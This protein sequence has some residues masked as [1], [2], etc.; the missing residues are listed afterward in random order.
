MYDPPG[1]PQQKLRRF[2]A[3]IN[4]SS[5]QAIR[6]DLNMPGTHWNREIGTSLAINFSHMD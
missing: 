5:S 1:W 6:T 4:S 3:M 2:R